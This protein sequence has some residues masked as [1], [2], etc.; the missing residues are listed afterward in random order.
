MTDAKRNPNDVLV[1]MIP[2]IVGGLIALI[3]SL[4]VLHYT[5]QAQ[6]KETLR[7]ERAGHVERA[8]SLA[9]RFL[10]ELNTAVASDVV[11]ARQGEGGE[12]VYNAPAN[13]LIELETVVRLYF[14]ALERDM[15]NLR[16]S[17]EEFTS[18]ADALSASEPQSTGVPDE[19]LAARSVEYRKKMEQLA[20]PVV[21]QANDL[22]E[23]LRK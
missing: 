1:S 12:D 11:A 19:V 13:T 18:G 21:K 2:V 17:Y 4:V 6:F 5:T 15:E 3:S 7:R 20:Q 16:K 22:I 10:R 9:A 14:P 23:H 8:T